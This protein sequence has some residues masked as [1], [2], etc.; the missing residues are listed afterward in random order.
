MSERFKKDQ[1]V[2]EQEELDQQEAEAR[3]VA[4]QETWDKLVKQ[5]MSSGLSADLA[6]IQAEAPQV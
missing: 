4:R 5:Y 1:E 2:R 6:L 3:R